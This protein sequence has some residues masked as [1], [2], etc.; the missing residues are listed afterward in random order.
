MFQPKVY[1]QVWQRLNQS[2]I[3][4]IS[5]QSLPPI[6]LK[7]YERLTSTNTQLWKLLDRGDKVPLAAIALEQ[8]GGQGQWGHSWVS[9]PG[10]LYLSVAWS[11]DLEINC[12]SHL[13]MAT[14]W[15]IAKV[16]RYYQ[17]P[18]TIK[19][20]NDLILKQ[21]KLGGIKIETRSH[22]HKLT[23]MVV[24]VG[25]NWCNPVPNLGINL[26]SYYQ[27]HTAPE[28]S[29][30]EELT[31][32]ASY[33]IVLGYQY[34]LTAGIESLLQEYLKILNSL[35]KSVTVN[36]SSGEVT[37]VTTDGKLKVKLRSP[38]ATTEISFDPGQISLGY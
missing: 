23:Q 32:I 16:L 15:G 29:S 30:L 28:I 1:H 18:V 25:L 17:L 13:V 14:A 34:Y 10:G 33:G 31:A 22:H 21:R 12:H 36:N 11:L 38:G 26:Q 4:A 2:Q 35:G 6:P 20:S 27:N 9:Q 7:V 24:G 5:P 8:T 37:G 19:W 3:I